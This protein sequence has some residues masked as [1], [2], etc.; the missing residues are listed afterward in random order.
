MTIV[1]PRRLGD[2]HERALLFLPA[3]PLVSMNAFAK[4]DSATMITQLE[5]D[6]NSASAGDHP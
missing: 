6:T 5:Y 2:P 3:T 4:T 1:A